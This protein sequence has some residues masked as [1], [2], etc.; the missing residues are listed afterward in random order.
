[1]A[2]IAL[3]TDTSVITACSNDYGYDRLFERQVEGLGNENDVL[4]GISTSGNSENV[5]RA[6]DMAKTKNMKTICLN[7]KDGGKIKEKY[8]HSNIIIPSSNTARIQESHETIFHA[9]CKLI[10]E[11]F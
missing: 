1:M 3:T 5:I 2:A 6:F 4:V 7:G 8:I 9:W 10:D 11:S